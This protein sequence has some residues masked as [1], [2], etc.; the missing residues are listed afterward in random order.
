MATM[1]IQHKIKDY[2][3]WKKVFDSFAGLRTSSGELSSQIYRDSSDPN[4]LTILNKWNSTENA[5]KYA[6][7]PGVK[8]AMEKAGVVGQPNVSFLNDA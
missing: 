5:K 1:L 6:H 2:A 7:S 3:E 8:T 4:S